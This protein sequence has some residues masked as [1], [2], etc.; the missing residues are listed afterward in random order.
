MGM[1]SIAHRPLISMTEIDGCGVALL[2]V[3]LTTRLRRN[4]KGS[5]LGYMNEETKKEYNIKYKKVTQSFAHNSLKFGFF[6]AFQCSTSCV[7]N[8]SAF[9]IQHCWRVAAH[10]GAVL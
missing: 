2:V 7:W 3:L 4:L 9:F 6:R 1:L 10:A 8:V 5:L